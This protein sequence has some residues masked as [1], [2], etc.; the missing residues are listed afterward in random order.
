MN[1]RIC[2]FVFNG[3]IKP[4]I[5]QQLIEFLLSMAKIR[6]LKSGLCYPYNCIYKTEVLLWKAEVMLGANIV[7]IAWG[8]YLLVNLKPVIYQPKDKKQMSPRLCPLI[9]NGF[10]K[11]STFQQLIECLVSMAKERK[12]KFG[13]YRI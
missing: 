4:A 1:P 10:I 6:K 13:L 5:F 8:S 12:L 7:W 2:P 9:L 3:F 11:P